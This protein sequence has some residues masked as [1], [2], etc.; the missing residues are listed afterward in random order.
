M[1]LRNLLASEIVRTAWIGGLLSVGLAVAC[2]PDT[3]HPTQT[4]RVG[5]TSTTEPV[6]DDGEMVLYE[7]RTSVELPILLPE[8]ADWDRL[9]SS[10]PAPF[11]RAPW[12]SNDDLEVQLV[13]TLSNLDAEAHNVYV[14]VDPHSEFGRYWPGL[15]LVDAEDGEFIPNLS[16]MDVRLELPGTADELGRSSRVRRVYD[17]ADVR[18]MM[19]DFATVMNIL[20]LGVVVATDAGM[21]MV[22]SSSVGLVN[23][24]FSLPNRSGSSP[25]VDPYQPAVIPG[26]TGFDIGLRTPE[27]ANIAIEVVVEVVDRNGERLRVES[28][29]ELLAPSEEIITAGSEAGY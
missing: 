3:A 15:A 25:L 11:E 4:V 21:G 10:Q 28:N 16:G 18:E 29:D 27:P 26:V 2:A 12:V 13:W 14:L 24:A 1:K 8:Q 23:H 20:E 19:I 5:M 17:F 22:E 9:Y 6:F 7:V